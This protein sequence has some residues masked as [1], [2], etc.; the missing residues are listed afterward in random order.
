M[1]G[2]YPTSGSPA[3]VQRERELGIGSWVIHNDSALRVSHAKETRKP[4]A[5]RFES[6]DGHRGITAPARMH[7]VI[8]AA[9]EA[10]LHPTV[11]K[12]ESQR[13]LDP[14]RRM[15]CGCRLPCG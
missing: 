2:V 14:N 13:R 15:Q 7:D 12:V 8:L 6:I 10:A 9:T 3:K 4:P 5:L 11:H 1:S